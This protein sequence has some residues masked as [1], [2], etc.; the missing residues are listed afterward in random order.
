VSA[1]HSSLTNAT[2]P[3]LSTY[4]RSWITCASPKYRQALESSI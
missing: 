2:S 1:S 3:E 4:W